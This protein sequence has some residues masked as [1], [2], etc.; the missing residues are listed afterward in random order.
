MIY[1][2]YKNNII[3]C[4]GDSITLGKLPFYTYP[5]SL[6]K[7]L[8]G[9]YIYNKGFGGSTTSDMV[10]R[11]NN[12]VIILKPHYII[13]LGGINDDISQ[14]EITKKNLIFL[15]DESKKNGII[16][17]ACTLL[18]YFR[19]SNF[20]KEINNWIRMYTQINGIT[21]VDFYDIMREPKNYLQLN[22]LYDSGDGLHPN[23]NG[24][25]HMGESINIKIFENQGE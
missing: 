7:R 4:L 25:L 19:Y 23:I 3:V 18:P 14:I 12:D 8:K 17:I 20:V 13:I 22:P 10:Y 21:L 9:F 6:K 24:Y 11:F 5:Q 2:K 16:P 15:Y 1:N